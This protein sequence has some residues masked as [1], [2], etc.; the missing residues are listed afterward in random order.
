MGTSERQRLRHGIN[1]NSEISG[2][3]ELNDRVCPYNSVRSKLVRKISE[4]TKK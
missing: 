2:N 4:H 1:D 3:N